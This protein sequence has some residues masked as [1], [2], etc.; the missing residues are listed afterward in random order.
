MYINDSH[1]LCKCFFFFVTSLFFFF[2]Q[3]SEEEREEKMEELWCSGFELIAEI[4]VRH[5]DYFKV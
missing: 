3:I 5:T 1:N 4:K 2:S